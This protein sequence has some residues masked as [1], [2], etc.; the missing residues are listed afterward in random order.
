M[1]NPG[2]HQAVCEGAGEP[3]APAVVT[4]GKTWTYRELLEAAERVADRLG[5]R[6]LAGAAVTAHVTDPTAATVLTLGCDLAGIPL[7]HRDPAT[8]GPPEG[9]MVYDSTASLPDT[10]EALGTDPPM[11]LH[12]GE[13][14]RVPYELPDQSQ[15]FLTSGSTGTPV[16]VVRS[17]DA[18]LAD[19][20]RVAM[21]LG[22]EPGSPVAVAAPPFHAY[23]FNYG[24]LAPLLHGAPVRHL[25]P[26]SLPSQLARAVREHGARTLIALPFHHGLLSRTGE[27]ALP[28]LRDGLS[29]LRSAVSAGAPLGTGVA[30]AVAKLFTFTLYTCYGS[31]EAGAVTLTR[32]ADTADTGWIGSPLPGISTRVAELEG[33]PEGGE[34]ML[35]SDQLAT[36]RLSH[37]GLVSLERD[38]EGW[39]HTGDLARIRPGTD[40]I[41]LL[42]RL[43]SVINVAGKKVNPMEVEQVLARH[44]AVT[45]NHVTAA[46]DRTHGQIP[47]ALVAVNGGVTTEDLVRWCRDRLAPHQVPRKIALLDEIPRSTT[48]KVLRSDVEGLLR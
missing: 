20:R 31:S 36:G 3:G 2:I 37:N 38:A 44:P 42:G 39:Y 19:A 33:F 27:S 13:R 7:I 8:P 18:V 32:A 28:A 16:G 23:G 4:R 48:G 34:L 24:L 41:Q 43:G 25:S 17:V 11:W 29:S 26:R 15:V 1:T 9:P 6:M 30:A 22:Y 46:D 5:H 12:N 40:G 35:C 45:D 14:P 10:A 21:F 47:V